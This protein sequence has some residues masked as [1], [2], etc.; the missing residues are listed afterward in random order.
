MTNALLLALT[1]AAGDPEVG[2]P[3]PDFTLEDTEGRRHRLSDLRGKLVVLEWTSHLCPGVAAHYRRGWLPQTQK[4]LEGRVVWLAIDSNGFCKR[5]VDDIE[6]WR[7]ERGVRHPW[8]LDPSGAVGRS[9]GAAATPQLFVVDARG[10]LA[11]AGALRDNDG[12]RN[13]LL[14]AVAAIEA[15]RTADPARTPARGCMIAYAAPG[16][17]EAADLYAE[18]A[19]WSGEAEIDPPFSLLKA[20]FR[21][22]H[23]AP[24]RVLTDAAF[25]KLRAG[26]ARKR[27]R[28]ILREA[29][30]ESRM[31]L[32]PPDEPGEPLVF[33]GRV[34][35][36]SG[37]PV[38]GALVY[39]FHTDRRGLYS[40]GGMDESN[41]RL[42]GYLRT[43]ADGRFELRTIRPGHYPD[44]EEPVEQHIHFEIEAEGFAKK[45]DRLGF[46]DDPFWAKHGKKPPA[47]AAPVTREDGA[48][49]RCE[50]D[51]VIDR[52]SR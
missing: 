17:D 13:Y 30:R 16:G 40:E 44:Q 27:L 35:D 24:S 39:A 37:R 22:G 34:V 6:A 47:W 31:T 1:L 15:K 14:D 41:P 2:K 18:A 21:A 23:P 20:A 25:A 36:R 10:V 28:A 9:F 3:A 11:Y 50:R 33:V 46:R 48:P 49:P 4:S 19:G 45:I 52:E 5:V 12:K 29:A 43:G 8:L 51:L 32:V 7:K 42:F 26:E 38:A